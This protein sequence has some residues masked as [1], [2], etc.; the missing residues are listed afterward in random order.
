MITHRATLDISRG[1][2]NPALVRGKALPR[3]ESPAAEPDLAATASAERIAAGLCDPST[4]SHARR[5]ALKVKVRPPGWQGLSTLRRSTAT[6]TK[7]GVRS[8]CSASCALPSD[9]A[10]GTP[11]PGDHA[12]KGR[13][14]SVAEAPKRQPAADG[15]R[16]RDLLRRCGASHD[17][18]ERAALLARIADELEAAAADI[19]AH[20]ESGELV[21]GLRG[22]ASMA[23]FIAEIDRHDETRQVS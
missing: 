5:R 16:V 11:M 8:R 20:S 7:T 13:C 12:R 6:A 4:P 19:A 2:A 15:V 23:R 17:P 21:A 3:A 22:Q 9:A 10:C 18:G 14:V 1:P